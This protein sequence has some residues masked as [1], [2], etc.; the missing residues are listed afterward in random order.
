MSVQASPSA[1]APERR[2]SAAALHRLVAVGAEG[3]ASGTPYMVG[4][5]LL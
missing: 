2:R 5:K 3:V 1:E 4:S